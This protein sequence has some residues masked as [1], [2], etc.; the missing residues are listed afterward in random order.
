MLDESHRN[1]LMAF[2]QF[3]TA[4]IISQKILA[5]YHMLSYCPYSLAIIQYCCYNKS[6]YL[7][8]RMPKVFFSSS[9]LLIY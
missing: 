6:G 2:I 7:L 1:A 8:R 9:A 5:F 3:I 4:Y